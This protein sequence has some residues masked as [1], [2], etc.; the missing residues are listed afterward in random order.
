MGGSGGDLCAA[1][2]GAEGAACGG[3][4]AVAAP[5]SLQCCCW[6]VVAA[7]AVAGCAAGGTS[8]VGA[9][10]EAGTAL[11]SAAG[12]C[13]C[14]ADEERGGCDGAGHGADGDGAGDGL[15]G[16][17]TMSGVEARGEGERTGVEDVVE[18]A[19][20]LL[21]AGLIDMR[22][23]C[24]RRGDCACAA[25]MVCSGAML[26][27]A[28]AVCGEVCGRVEC[29]EVRVGRAGGWGGVTVRGV[30]LACRVGF[31]GMP[32]MQEGLACCR[33]GWPA[34]RA[35]R[36]P[37]MV[38]AAGGCGERGCDQCAPARGRVDVAGGV[39]RGGGGMCIWEVSFGTGVA[40]GAEG[41]EFCA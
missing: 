6:G 14:A 41:A 10:G 20:R 16:G 17:A 15:A 5:V 38:A 25:C 28:A 4:A 31:G 30:H 40:G 1:P 12:E 9:C 33:G 26:W 23:A 7:A 18:D 22:A 13:V 11:S 8:L 29:G 39:T 3:L 37:C 19:E 21:P 27:A 35:H 32:G 34:A 2:G 24:M 36:F